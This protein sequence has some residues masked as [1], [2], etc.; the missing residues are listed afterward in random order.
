MIRVSL[1]VPELYRSRA[2]YV[3]RIFALRWGIP[4]LFTSDEP[5]LIYSSPNST[6]ATGDAFCLP[7]DES[8]YQPQTA[9]ALRR[10][11]AGSCWVVAGDDREWPDLVGTTYRLLTHLD[12]SHVSEDNR[13]RRG[14]FVNAALPPDRAQ[15]ASVPLVEYHAAALLDQ[16]LRL[17]PRL[18]EK[19]I[20]RWPNAKQ[21]ALVL[22]HDVDATNVSAPLEIAA[23]LAKALLRGSGVNARLF[24]LG[25][26]GLRRGSSNLYF[27]FQRWKDW[28]ALRNLK[29]AFYLFYR[30]RRVRFDINDC[31]SSVAAR[32]TDWKTLRKISREGWEFGLHSSIRSR[33]RPAAIAEAREWLEGKLAGP[34]RGVRHHYWSIDWR[35]P[36]RTHRLQAESG[37]LYDSS[38]AWRDQAGFRAGTC[39][40]YAPYDPEAEKAL[41]LT[42]LPCNLMDGHILFRN[43]SGARRDYEEAVRLGHQLMEIVKAAGGAAVLDW[44]QEKGFNRL[45]CPGF[46]DVL[47]AV[48]EPC[49]T[50][51][52]AWIALPREVVEHWNT[53]ADLI[54][55]TSHS[56]CG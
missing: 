43:V 39:L 41:P 1:Q 52:D 9:C 4:I 6:V 50:D 33:E 42:E 25:V 28:E 20:P 11:D 16:L 8:A 7:F 38:I 49:L 35:A 21:Y 34:I 54:L 53:R 29:S 24:A 19:S 22:T 27:Q 12:E 30:P 55:S 15:S 40:P 13:D 48:L 14:I 2:A 36:H 56:A 3:I 47:D 17:R 51:S 5:D 26:F 31:R 46:F 45:E 37:F 23:N 44:H 32:Q 10:R 18:A